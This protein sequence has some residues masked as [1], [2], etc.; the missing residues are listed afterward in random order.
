MLFSTKVFFYQFIFP[1]NDPIAIKTIHIS[2]M[3]SIS[4]Y[5]FL[6]I[7]THIYHP[8]LPSLIYPLYLPPHRCIFP[9]LLRVCFRFT[10]FFSLSLLISYLPSPFSLFLSMSFYLFLQF[11][12][13]VLVCFFF[14]LD[15]NFVFTFSI[16]CPNVTIFLSLLKSRGTSF[17]PPFHFLRVSVFV[18]P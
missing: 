5:F 7:S 9:F 4:T 11:G 10:P 13:F 14:F 17:R 12:L 6:I 18:V 2:A 15:S 16:I 3:F 8:F 1:L